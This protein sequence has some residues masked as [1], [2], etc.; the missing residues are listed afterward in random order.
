MSVDY[1]VACHKCKERINLAGYADSTVIRV[2]G[3]F[4]LYSHSSHDVVVLNDITGWDDE[5]DK[6][7]FDALKYKEVVWE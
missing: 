3:E 6:I 1:T 5:Y 2:T 7:Y 4:A